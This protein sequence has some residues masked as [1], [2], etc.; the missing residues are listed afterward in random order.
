LLSR[1][2]ATETNHSEPGSDESIAFSASEAIAAYSRRVKRPS[3][4]AASYIG[5][6]DGI[7]SASSLAADCFFSPTPMMAYLYQNRAPV[8]IRI[9][10]ANR[11]VVFEILMTKFSKRDNG[12]DNRAESWLELNVG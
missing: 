3:A 4:I 10:T 5:F 12:Q 6:T 8:K 2:A 7:R 1:D 9:A 11:I